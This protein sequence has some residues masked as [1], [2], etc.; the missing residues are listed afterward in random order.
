[1][2]QNYGKLLRDMDRLEDSE[3]ELRLAL[4][5]TDASD[6]RTRSSLAET[7]T[8]VGKT[9]EAGRLIGDL[10]RSDAADP[11]AL[12]AQG[13]LLSARGKLEEAAKSLSAAADSGDTD[14][15][16][17]LARVYVRMG[18]LP[19]AREAAGAVIA[20][21]PGHPWAL[22]VL[23]QI[24]VLQGHREEGLALLR[25]A[26][27]SRPR[28]PEAWLSLAEG[29]EAAKDPGAAARCRHAAQALR[30]G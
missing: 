27:A 26:E 8:L 21:T 9:D 7:L 15:R 19:R 17:D 30:A 10:L 1:V 6:R 29:F 14:A 25:R 13:R 22:A 11:E 12:A 4:E 2:R 28:R 18:D 3:K 20:T 16:I 23:G 5:Q 24:V